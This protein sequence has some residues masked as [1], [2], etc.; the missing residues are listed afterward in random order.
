VFWWTSRADVL[1]ECSKTL[2]RMKRELLE[3]VNEFRERGDQSVLKLVEALNAKAFKGDVARA[4]KAKVG[5]CCIRFIAV[6][7]CYIYYIC[8]SYMNNNIKGR[9]G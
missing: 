7:V 9:C 2:Q 3:E 6:Y 8:V 1:E 4:L 5:C